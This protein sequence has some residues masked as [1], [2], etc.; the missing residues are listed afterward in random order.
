MKKRTLV[1]GPRLPVSFVF[2]LTE[3][4]SGTI[5]KWRGDFKMS[6]FEIATLKNVVLQGF[7]GRLKASKTAKTNFKITDFEIGSDNRILFGDVTSGHDPD[8]LAVER[9]AEGSGYFFAG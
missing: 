1:Y 5:V 7:S 4:K 6:D 2:F 3:W 9:H 8:R